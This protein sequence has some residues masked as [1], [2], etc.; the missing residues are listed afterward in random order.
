MV[1]DIIAPDRSGFR[2]LRAI[3]GAL[4]VFGMRIVFATVIAAAIW[5]FS[6][7]A[8]ALLLSPAPLWLAALVF[9]GY[10]IALMVA[11]QLLNWLVAIWRA[12]RDRADGAGA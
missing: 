4:T 10:G 11:G 3:A 7:Q 6:D 12:Q 8:P 9:T 2:L 1:R 5:V